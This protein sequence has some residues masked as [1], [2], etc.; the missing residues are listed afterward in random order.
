[1][2][3]V[4]D[5]CHQESKP[6]LKATPIKR[7]QLYIWA[8]ATS[9]DQS[10]GDIC[11]SWQ[12]IRLKKI[13]TDCYGEPTS[14]I[15]QPV[16]KHRHESYGDLSKKLV[17]HFNVLMRLDLPDPNATELRGQS[18]IGITPLEILIWSMVLIFCWRTRA[19]PIMIWHL[20]A[21]AFAVCYSLCYPLNRLSLKLIEN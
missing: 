5:Q 2:Q 17:Q 3:R 1:M 16:A 18:P 21:F 9:I 12:D 8:D 15:S 10:E 13:R 7:L 11:K 14:L 20:V 19:Y 6:R 4:H